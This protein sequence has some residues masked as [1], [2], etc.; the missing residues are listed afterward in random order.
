MVLFSSISAPAGDDPTMLDATRN[1]LPRL[2]VWWL[3]MTVV[4][5]TAFALRLAPVL[6]GG[7][8]FGRGNY[9]DGVY[10]ASAAGFV[11]GL[12]PYRDFLILHP[13]GIVL[14]LAPFAELARWIGEP[15]AFAAARVFFMLIGTANAILVGVALRRLGAAA[16]LT[17]G[18]F[19]AVFYPAVYV[20]HSTLL[21]PLA[22]TCLLGAIGLIAGT[23]DA[24]PTTAP[25]PTKVTLWLAAAGVLLGISASIKIW[26][27][28]PAVAVIGW[29]LVALG[30]RRALTISAGVAIG[31]TAICLPFFA[32]APGQMWRLVVLSQLGRPKAGGDF[33]QRAGMIAGLTPLDTKPP[34]WWLAVAGFVVAGCCLAA[35]RSSVGRLFVVVLAACAAM[36]FVTPSWFVHYAAL[37]AGPLALVVGAAAGWVAARVRRALTATISA[38]VVIGL[39]A[40]YASTVVTRPFGSPFPTAALQPVVAAATT[41][42]TTDDP[43]SLIELNVLRRNMQ[44]GCPLVVDLGGYN[45]AMQVG[46]RDFRIRARNP[47]W[48]ALALDYLRSGDA[49]VVGIRFH[50]GSGYSTATAKEI[51]SWPVLGRAGKI[52]VRHPGA[53]LPDR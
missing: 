40:G 27:M 5:A 14:A 26:G 37:T 10:Y 16:A 30:W 53:P 51:A 6:A 18:L 24:R 41:C 20:E 35:A 42:V 21:E 32:A 8:L 33:F 13:P 50:R 29:A 19:Y 31:A 47:E 22:T 44:R 48:Q 12:M 36:L 38:T 7:G 15:S 11:H 4:G 1:R 23:I 17:G 45:Y 25:A 52:A 46:T 34:T 39:L 2:T 43:I 9:D 28:E 3:G 49:T